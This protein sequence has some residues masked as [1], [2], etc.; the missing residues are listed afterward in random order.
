MNKHP[1]KKTTTS[2][3]TLMFGTPGF[4]LLMVVLVLYLKN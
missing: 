4:V 3:L 1:S 2:E